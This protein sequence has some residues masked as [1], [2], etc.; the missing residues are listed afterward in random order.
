MD[1][2]G[3]EVWKSS[4]AGPF[5]TVGEVTVWPLLDEWLRVRSPSGNEEVEGFAEAKRRARELAGV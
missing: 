2:L 1:G 3:P 5:L 4:A